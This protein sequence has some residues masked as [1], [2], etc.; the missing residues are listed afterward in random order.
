MNKSTLSR[1]LYAIGKMYNVRI[2]QD[3]LCLWELVLEELTDEEFLQGVKLY[4]KGSNKF[5]PQPGEIL[6]LV[7]PKFDSK[8]EASEIVD[9]I[10]TALSKY[11][12][13]KFDIERA[14]LEIGEIGWSYIQKLGGWSLWGQNI[15]NDQV[16]I[17]KS[18]MRNSLQ[19][20]L[21]TNHRVKE[22]SQPNNLMTLKDYNVSIK[23]IE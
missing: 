17:L 2:E 10:F 6:Q 9:R 19:H 7:K 23:M 20:L 3:V 15:T 5:F 16:P 8:N 12:F 13:S 21:D 4:L 11:G 18:Q 14:K 22:F 1:T